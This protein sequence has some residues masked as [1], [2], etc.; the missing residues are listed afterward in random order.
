MA[1]VTLKV[2]VCGGGGFWLQFLFE[3][4]PPPCSTQNA[5]PTTRMRLPSHSP[6]PSPSLAQMKAVDPDVGLGELQL[7]QQVGVTVY[8]AV[9]AGLDKHSQWRTPEDACSGVSTQ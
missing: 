7:P 2:C 1:D 5:T 9:L 6:S 4:S 8:G 3:H